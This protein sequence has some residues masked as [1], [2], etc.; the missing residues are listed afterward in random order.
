MANTIVVTNR[1]IEITAMDEDYIMEPEI[2][3]ESVVF[4]PGAADDQ[5]EIREYT[6]DVATS[7]VKGLFMSGDG[8]PRIQYFRQRVRLCFDFDALTTTHT[9]GMKIIINTGERG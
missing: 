3:V 8:E 1:T 7:P 2:S 5:F 6:G 9:A 4:I